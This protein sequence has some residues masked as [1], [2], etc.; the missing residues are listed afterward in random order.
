MRKNFVRIAFLALFSSSIAF[1]VGYSAWTI[2]EPRSNEEII[3]IPV[4]PQKVCYIGNTYYTSLDKALDVAYSNL[5][6][7]TI[8]V[9]PNL[10]DT[11]E[12]KR[13]H[14]LKK[15]DTLCLPYEGQT[16]KPSS[17]TGSATIDSTPGNVKTYRKTQ[18]KFCSNTTLEITSGANLYVGGVYNT[19]GVTGNYCEISLDTNSSITCYGNMEVYGYI[20]EDESSIVTSDE[21]GVIDNSCDSGRFISF[22]SGSTLTY[23]LSIGDAQSGGTMTALNDAGTC[24]TNEFDLESLQT[25]VTFEYGSKATALARMSAAGETMEKECGIV[26]NDKSNPYVFYLESGSSFSMEYLPKTP[27][28]TKSAPNADYLKYITKGNVTFGYLNLDVTVTTIDTRKYFFPL[29]YKTR[30]Y[31]SSGST[32]T[33]SYQ[34]KVYPGS[35]FVIENGGTF[36]CSSDLV[37]YEKSDLSSLGSNDAFVYPLKLIEDDGLFVNNGTFNLESSGK[38][39]GEMTHNNAGDSKGVFTSSSS[40]NLTVKSV[41]G[42]QAKEIIKQATAIF[43]TSKGF[44][45]ALIGENQN[46][47]SSVLDNNYYWIGEYYL[48]LSVTFKLSAEFAH[49]VY[50][51]TIKCADNSNGSNSTNLSAENSQSLTSYSVN[52][53]KYIQIKTNRTKD[54]K[55]DFGDGNKISVDQN[56]WYPFNDDDVIVYL[57]PCEGVT[58]DITTSGNSGSGHV[59]YTLYE[60]SSKGGSY[61]QIATNGTGKLSTV[62]IKG[63]YFKFTSKSNYGYYYTTKPVYKDGVNIGAHGKE[64]IGFFEGLSSKNRGDLLEYLADGNYKFDFG[65]KSP[66]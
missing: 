18:V 30:L 3:D 60:S 17:F 14:I 28:L 21:S 45:K 31:I 20:K 65:W 26:G 52:S 40:S 25:Y 51:Y 66:V 54:A 6:N 13:S 43:L 29:S 53:Q 56:K 62:V 35:Q 57:T 47:T 16:Y 44:K 1:S 38:F 36:D 11:V 49:N 27:G 63:Y 64:N 22:K 39:G 7:D 24:P 12:M 46:L 5:S 34:I 61:T 9:I 48:T 42:S 50:G 10:K 15:G 19:K 58:V 8:Y 23:P 2:F 32:L 37:V 4:G 59:T 33:S 55:I 41:E